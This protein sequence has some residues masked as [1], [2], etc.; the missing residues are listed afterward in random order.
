MMLKHN[1]VFHRPLLTGVCALLLLSST[2]CTQMPLIKVQETVPQDIPASSQVLQVHHRNKINNLFADGF[3]EIG[4]YAVSKIKK[5]SSS[6]SSS[7]IGPYSQNS[8]KSG[9][10]FRVSDSQIHWDV[11]C[12]TRSEGNVLKI[13]GLDTVSQKRKLHCEMH[14]QQS[15]ASIEMREEMDSPIGE[16]RIN[17]SHFAVRAYSHGNPHPDRMRIP[18]TFGFRIDDNGRNY[19]AIELSDTPGR[20]WLNTSLPAEQKT[21]MVGMLAALLIQYGS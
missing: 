13:F 4:D 10:Q 6:T 12:E 16:V 2:A 3:F 11:R 5:D 8:T 14:S 20:A 19:A 18:E 7:Q 17:Q 1:R 21:A 9:F 15:N